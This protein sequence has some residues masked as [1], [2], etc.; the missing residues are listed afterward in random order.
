MY[1][2]SME[3]QEEIEEVL[4]GFDLDV[5]KFSDPVRVIRETAYFFSITI[6]VDE[7]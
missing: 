6:L 2:P 1:Q 7:R 5:R 3:E 4:E